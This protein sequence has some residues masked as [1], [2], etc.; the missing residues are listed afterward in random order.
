MNINKAAHALYLTN[1][2]GGWAAAPTAEQGGTSGWWCSLVQLAMACLQP[3]GVNLDPRTGAREGKGAGWY[4]WMSS[5]SA[6]S[7][8][9]CT[10][11]SP[12]RSQCVRC[13]TD[14]RP[15]PALARGLAAHAGGGESGVEPPSRS[16]ATG[17]THHPPTSPRARLVC[18]RPAP[19]ID[20]LRKVQQQE[21]QAWEE[22]RPVAAQE[23]QQLS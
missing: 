2:A 17:G 22:Q 15:Q 5:A 13:N 19:L 18:I 3:H 21:R 9:L 6:G 23:R 14:R 12:E 1:S 10:A 20:Q 11:I 7:A 4:W 16:P 8:E